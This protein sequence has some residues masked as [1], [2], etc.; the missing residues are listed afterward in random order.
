MREYGGGLKG[1]FKLVEGELAGVSP[2]EGGIFLGQVSKGADNFGVI[3]DK[4]S[5]EIGET[6]EGLNLLECSGGWPSVNGSGFGAVHGNTFGG[7]DEPEVFGAGGVEL[8][9]FG[10]DVEVVFAETLEH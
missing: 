6:K 3:V 7:Y 8:A 2:L 5:V 9:L 4:S 1:G 10:L